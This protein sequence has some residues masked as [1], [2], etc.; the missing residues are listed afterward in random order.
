MWKAM[1][2]K[3]R[4]NQKREDLL[5]VKVWVYCM[6]VAYVIHIPIVVRMCIE[7]RSILFCNYLYRHHY[8]KYVYYI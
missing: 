5:E 7:D 6:F 1:E 2:R 4:K 8:S 3:D